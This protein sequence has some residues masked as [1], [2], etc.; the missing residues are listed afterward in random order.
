V[1]PASHLPVAE[2]LLGV[3]ADLL[4]LG[5][6][7]NGVDREAESIGLVVDGQFHRSVDI[8][9]LFVAAHMQILVFAAV[10]QA[11]DEPRI[12]VEVENDGLVGGEQRIEIRIRQTVRMLAAR[13][14]LEKV[15]HVD[16]TDLQIGK[17]LA[18]QYRCGEGFLRRDVAGGSEGATA[19]RKRSR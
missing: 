18:E 14:H 12:T 8:A 3:P 16:E 19:C 10:G 1:G 9:L 2:L 15:H 13:L 5:Y 7:I 11:V 4:E 6:A 17:L